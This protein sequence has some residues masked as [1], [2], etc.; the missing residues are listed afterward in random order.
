MGL[1]DRVHDGLRPTN[2]IAVAPEPFQAPPKAASGAGPAPSST[3]AASAAPE[4]PGLAGKRRTYASEPETIAKAYYIEDTG[5]ERRYYDDYKR[6][7]LAMRA[8]ETSVSSKRE[9]LNTV[10]AM[11]DIAD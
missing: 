2:T 7:A 5:A 3:P 10:R 1:T 8:T 9:V 11:I 4:R 6:G